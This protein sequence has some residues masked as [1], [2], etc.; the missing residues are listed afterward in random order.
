MGIVTIDFIKD[1]FNITGSELDNRIAFFIPIVEASY[2]EIRNKAFE[3]EAGESD[4]SLEEYIIYPA[5]SEEVAAQMVMYKI[6][7]T[8][9]V[10]VTGSVV[11][12]EK[13]VKSE[14]W[15]DHS[16][17][18]IESLVFSSEL[19]FNYPVNIVSQ[20]RRYIGFSEA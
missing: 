6:K 17:S 19:K 16:I 4:E 14:S 12:T 3:V 9:S 18:Y 10:V 8:S 7:S 5:N 11:E 1:Y 20:I 15:G 13:E 2:L